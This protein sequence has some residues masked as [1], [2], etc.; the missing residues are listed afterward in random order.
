MDC[1]LCCEPFEED[2]HHAPRT[3]HCGHTFCT[4]CIEMLERTQPRFSARCPECRAFIRFHRIPPINFAK[5]FKLLEVIRDRKGPPPKPGADTTTTYNDHRGN[6]AT[7]LS[8]FVPRG[9]EVQE[10][11]SPLNHPSE[12]TLPWIHFGWTP[13]LGVDSDYEVEHRAGL[14]RGSWPHAVPRQAQLDAI[15]PPPRP[16]SR[17]FLGGVGGAPA[18]P[19]APVPPTPEATATATTST[20]PDEGSSSHDADIW[21]TNNTSNGEGLVYNGDQNAVVRGRAV[22]GD[23]G[24]LVCKFYQEGTCR[25]GPFCWFDHPCINPSKPMCK[26]WLQGRCRMGLS[27]N[28]RHGVLVPLQRRRR[29]RSQR[30]QRPG[31]AG[32]SG[33]AQRVE[34]EDSQHILHPSD[35]RALGGSQGSEARGVARSVVLVDGHGGVLGYRQWGSNNIVGQHQQVGACPRAGEATHFQGGER[36]SGEHFYDRFGTAASLSSQPAGRATSEQ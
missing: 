36:G 32:P 30:S 26:H 33:D 19:S 11:A 21:T 7:D 4:H 14:I 28:Y 16:S 3:L 34:E 1:S 35:G 9:S 18:R 10:A 22:Q 6:D 27:C 31:D 25:Y 8:G 12:Q 29:H 13:R 17:L 20:T 5:N 23:N 15:V 24:G 2:G